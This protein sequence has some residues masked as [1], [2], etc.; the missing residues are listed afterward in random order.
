MFSFWTINHSALILHFRNSGPHAEAKYLEIGHSYPI[1][2]QTGAQVAA[3]TCDLWQNVFSNLQIKYAI[4]S[5]DDEILFDAAI[6]CLILVGS[7]YTRSWLLDLN[8]LLLLW[9]LGVLNNPSA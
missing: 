8:L 2:A 4:G 3:K 5:R 1:D 6:G 9:Q 7:R